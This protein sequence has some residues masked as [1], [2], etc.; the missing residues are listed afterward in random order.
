M[1]CGTW[2][3]VR[4]KILLFQLNLLAEIHSPLVSCAFILNSMSA[5]VNILLHVNKQKPLSMTNFHLLKL[6]YE[7]RVFWT[8]RVIIK[9]KFQRGWLNFFASIDIISWF[10]M[11]D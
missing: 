7:I 1:F 10:R 2:Y 6:V 11:I 4:T 9:N 5:K 8:F 3:K